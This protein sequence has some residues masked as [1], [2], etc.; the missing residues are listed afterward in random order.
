M[1]LA[2]P[3]QMPAPVEVAV[4]ADSPETPALPLVR[5]MNPT[6]K[7]LRFIVPVSDGP[8]YLGDVELIVAPD[9][10]LSIVAPRLEQLLEPLLKRDIFEK[11]RTRIGGDAE[12][13]AATLGEF[14]IRIAYDD[15]KLALA[16]SVPVEER[17]LSRLSLR[18]AY[19]NGGETLAPAGVS[20]Y[21]NLRGAM[22]LSEQGSETGISAPEF[23]LD[24]AMRLG[25]VVA[26]SEGYA[27]F[28]PSVPGFRRTGSRLVYDDLNRTMRWQAGDLHPL[29]Q[30]FQST[31]NMA[32][33]SVTRLYSILD[34]QREV[35]SSGAQSFSLFAPSVVETVVNGRIVERRTLQPGNYSL[36]DFPLAD[37]ANRVQLQIEDPTGQRRTID[38]DLYYS[39]TLLAPGLVEFSAIAGVYANPSFDGISYTDD[40]AAS[41]FVRK[42]ITQQLTAGANFQ[43]DRLAQQGGVELLFGS[44]PGL[45]GANLSLS[46][47]NTGQ[48]GFAGSLTFEKTTTGNGYDGQSFHASAEIR[49]KDFATPG[50]LPRSEAIKWRL[51][52][53]YSKNFSRDRF[54]TADIQ[55]A[56]NRLTSQNQIS[57]RVGF[58]FRM[59]RDVGGTIEVQ[60]DHGVFRDGFVARFGIRKRFGLRSNAHADVDTDGTF[61]AGYQTGGGDGI[62]AWSGDFDLVRNVDDASL[63]ANAY[64]AGNR[65]EGIVNQTVDYDESSDRLTSARTSLRFATAIAFADGAV[66]IGRPV[67]DSFL[68]ARAH[69]SLDGHPVRVDPRATG[70]MA[71]SGTLGPALVGNL[72]PYSERTMLYEVDNPPTG[73]DLGAGNVQIDPKYR[74]GY[75]L[76]VGSDYHLLVVGKLLNRLGEPISLLTGTATELAAPKRPGITVFT[77]RDGRFVAQGLR[78][79][80]WRIAMASEPPAVFEFDLPGETAGSAQGMIRIGTLKETPQEQ[81]K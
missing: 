70:E 75:S 39:R 65:F 61:R 4:V 38:F 5:R 42:G 66:A 12:V 28:R 67:T 29:A 11:L 31:P 22:D 43:A 69:S 55:Y 9:D 78:P 7:A 20:G 51:L 49:S 50:Q 56:R 3:A 40:W 14:G 44:A 23:A 62:G 19:A 53:G 16:V 68:I 74:A 80:R 2:E 24:G 46:Q 1:F 45:I 41:G 60:Y 48:E 6:G 37:G 15:A 17:E 54:V 10:S 13:S 25:E 81:G 57:S 58:G 8:T 35:R 32:G 33:L 71:R 21:V 63:N 26:E 79:G 47:R 64:Y 27:S 76:T 18:S 59:N 30:T 34:P 77:T 73:Y 72:S 52:A 36:N